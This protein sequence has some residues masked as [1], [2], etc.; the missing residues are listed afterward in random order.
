LEVVR[1]LIG[2]HAISYCKNVK[3]KMKNIYQIGLM[4]EKIMVKLDAI[5]A[6]VNGLPPVQIQVSNRFLPTFVAL[7]KLGYGTASG[8]SCV[9][10]RA[11]AFESKNLNEMYSLGLLTKQ[12]DG[13]SQV[14]HPRQP[15]V[16]S[17]PKKEAGA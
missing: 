3:A 14:F 12:R 5:D 13:K 6:K 11:R 8:I 15:N 1:L 7:T 4:M 9:T 16:F 10:G 17:A 2:F